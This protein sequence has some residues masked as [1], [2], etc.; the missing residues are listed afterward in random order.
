MRMTVQNRSALPDEFFWTFVEV[1]I[2][3]MVC[4]PNARCTMSQEAGLSMQSRSEGM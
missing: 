3:S 2:R 4:G 1:A